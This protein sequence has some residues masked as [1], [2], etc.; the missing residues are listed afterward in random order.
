MVSDI[1]TMKTL[2]VGA[3]AT[4]MMAAPVQSAVGE[5][6]DFQSNPINYPSDYRSNHSLGCL[7]L[8]ECAAGVVELTD[9]KVLEDYYNKTF[10]VSSEFDE[11]LGSLRKI[12]VKV[13]LARGE[14]FPPRTRG[15]YH[16]LSNIFY[17]NDEW[18]FQENHLMS[19]LRHEGWHA[20]QDCMAGTIDNAQIAVIYTEDKIPGFWKETAKRTYPAHVLPWE[21]EAMWAGHTENLTRD[22]LRA[23]ETGAMWDQPGYEPTP[24]TR[25][26]LI[27]KG[28][29]KP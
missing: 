26:Y 28:Y 5:E 24:L 7:L 20:A 3:L 19:V 23:C 27:D 21:Q 9:R 13:Y 29:I 14:Y 10:N 25:Q 1:L 11:I 22:A 6:V 18:M 16:P 17:L 4:L 12:G 2:L 8:Q 15:V